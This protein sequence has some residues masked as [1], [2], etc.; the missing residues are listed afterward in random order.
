MGIWNECEGD[1]W[2]PCVTKMENEKKKRILSNGK[3]GLETDCVCW[4]IWTG[5]RLCLLK[6]MGWKQLVFAGKYGLENRLCVACHC[7]IWIDMLNCLCRFW[8]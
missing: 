3:Y 2:K 8:V 4:K 6:N 7:W 5:N 1:T